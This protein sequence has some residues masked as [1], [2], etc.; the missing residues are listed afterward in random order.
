MEHIT[1]SINKET[2][3]KAFKIDASLL[4]FTLRLPQLTFLPLT[5]ISLCFIG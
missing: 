3:I 4:K 2:L 1:F 5:V